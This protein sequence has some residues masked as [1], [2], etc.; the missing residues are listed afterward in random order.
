M[1]C[2]DAIPDF[3]SITPQHSWLCMICLIHTSKECNMRM[4]AGGH[5]TA[6]VCISTSSHC[7]HSKPSV[8][9]ERGSNFAVVLGS[10]CPPYRIQEGP[11]CTGYSGGARVCC[12]DWQ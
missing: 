11:Q 1:P 6:L 5:A 4:E 9:C 3:S 2:M 8:V 7:H 12:G 10:S